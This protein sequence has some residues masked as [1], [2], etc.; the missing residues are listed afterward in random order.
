MT[1]KEQKEI[2][3]QEIIENL[4]EEELKILETPVESIPPAIVFKPVPLA[5]R[6]TKGVENVR[7]MVLKQRELVTKSATSVDAS[8]ERAPES[9]MSCDNFKKVSIQFTEQ[10]DFPEGTFES[11]KKDIED[12]RRRLRRRS[13]RPIQTDAVPAED[14][15]DDDDR[16][17]V[18]N[19][20]ELTNLDK[21]GISIELSF[22]SALAVSSKGKPDL[23][24]VQL[25]LGEYKGLNGIPMPASMVKM[26][27]IPRQMGS[28]EEA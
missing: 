16:D 13:R 5:A 28:L 1:Y 8:G 23:L 19:G 27:E 6:M 17:S 7:E 26:I 2:E 10:V 9:R 20:W 12:D 21:D 4:E 3:V 25:D 18:I 15:S 14:D 22:S 11:I 24:L